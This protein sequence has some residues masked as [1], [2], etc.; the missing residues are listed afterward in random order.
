MYQIE[1]GSFGSKEVGE[2]VTHFIDNND[3][4]QIVV[5][6]IG[7]YG[8]KNLL[9]VQGSEDSSLPDAWRHGTASVLNTVRWYGGERIWR[10]AKS[11][12]AVTG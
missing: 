4:C 3:L 1:F 12:L 11:F 10:K 6:A 9:L 5:W 8:E 7:P 2:V